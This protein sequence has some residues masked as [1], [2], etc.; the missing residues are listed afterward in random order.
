M[1][2]ATVLATASRACAAD[3]AYAETPQ[4]MAQ[5]FGITVPRQHYIGFEARVLD[6]G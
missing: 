4:R 1:R 3:Q 5:D 6:E 2:A